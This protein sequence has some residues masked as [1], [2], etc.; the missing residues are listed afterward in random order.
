V[1]VD[2]TDFRGLATI[3]C[4]LAFA[5]VVFWAYGPSRKQYFDDAAQLPFTDQGEEK[6]DE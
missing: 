6:A 1:N 3:F 5:A 4:A 2:I